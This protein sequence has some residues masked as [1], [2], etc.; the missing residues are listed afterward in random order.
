LRL[1]DCQWCERTE[2]DVCL[3]SSP[4]GGYKQ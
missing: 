3:C 2:A 4:P 1:T